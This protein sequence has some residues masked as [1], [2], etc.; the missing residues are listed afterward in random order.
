MSRYVPHIRPELTDTIRTSLPVG[1][2]DWG[3]LGALSNWSNGHGG[4]LI[5]WTLLGHTVSSGATGTFLFHVA[6]KLPCVERVWNVNMRAEAPAGVTAAVVAGGASSVT[7][8]LTDARDGRGGSYRFRES[9]SSKTSTVA[10]TEIKITA[11]GGN[12][13]VESV[14]MYEQTRGV[15]DA[16][17]DDYGVDADSLRSRD[18]IADF[19]Y[20]SVAGVMDGY[21]NLDARRAGFFHWSTDVGGAVSTTAGSGTPDAFF[22]LSI[23]VLGAIPTIGDT[24]TTVTVA[25]MASV[26]AG[27][28]TVRFQSDDAGDSTSVDITQTAMTAWGTK[29]LSIN[30]EDFSVTDGRR[31]STWEGIAVDTWVTATN[32]LTIQ[33]IS[34]YRTTTPL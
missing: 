30:C 3:G 25:V 24:T 6:P 18:P 22:P 28:G 23:P 20:Q 4:M 14:S 31:G 8:S 26:D 1:A 15:L 2:F 32:T 34:I 12:L 10:E 27:T 11:A 16:T 9:L 29:T 13:V 33:A 7:V 17:T 5:P 19:A 21:K